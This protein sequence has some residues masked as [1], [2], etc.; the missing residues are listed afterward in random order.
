MKNASGSKST[1]IKYRILRLTLITVFVLVLVL[2]ISLYI[3]VKDAY[4]SSYENETRSL[5][6]AYSQT[7]QNTIDFLSMQIETAS[8][9][10]YVYYN[11]VPVE[12]RKNRLAELASTTM[13]KDFSVA[14]SDGTTY[15]D[16]DISDRDYFKNAM[17]GQLSISSP[18]LRKTDNSVTMMMAVPASFEEID[19][20]FYGA[21][22]C[23]QLSKGLDNIDMGE[24]SNIVVLDSNSQVIASSDTSKVIDMLV[25]SQSQNEGLKELSKHMVSGET[26]D[27]MYTSD[28]VEYLV[29]YQPL[30]DTG[31]SIAVTAN[32]SQ[33]TE[34][35]ISNLIIVNI[36]VIALVIASLIITTKVANKISIPINESVDRLSK[37]S[38][39]DIN[40]DFQHHAKNDE[41]YILAE[42]LSNTI[43]NLKMY[44]GD[45]QNVLAGIADGDLT[46]KSSVDYQ[47]D[48]IAIGNSLD[49]ITATMNGV[50]NN[51][52]YGVGNIQQGASQV[53]EGAQSL[54]N[55]AI[56]E[57]EAVDEISST[58]S[59]I[60]QKADN[61]ATISDYVSEL[62]TQANRNALDGEKLMKELAEAVENIREKS[63]AI[64]NISKTVEDIAFQTN[65]LSLNASIEAARAG[66][67]GKGFAVVAH[68]VG[69]LA[70][71]SAE[72]AQHTT[73]LIDESIQAVMS[74]SELAEKVSKAMVNI[75]GDIN[76][77]S[78]EMDKIV[79][80]AN[81]Q[82]LS[83][84][85]IASGMTHIESG[86][87]ST[88]ATAEQSAAS[89]EQLSSMSTSLADELSRFK[90]SANY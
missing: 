82:K 79:V 21:I 65:I 46:V 67:A 3:S 64:K 5:A 51:V 22:D 88:T 7:I 56:K 54:S 68:E 9:E 11:T 43:S 66:E 14:Y 28:G 15:N 69:D 8:K 31:W 85:N 84:E 53:A 52:K 20:V 32:Y 29:C 77:V 24:G 39:G 63:E 76:K 41:T 57:A 30:A 42:S 75:V 13:F 62:T 16:T 6:S 48:F 90:T 58:L 17:N 50:F 74:G 1:K 19:Y 86:M 61:T 10:D 87:H 80:A 73:V 70:T 81:E 45:I 47:G 34:K 26:G 55:I 59:S 40:S 27:M 89:S 78:D 33:V 60:Q 4:H 83:V 12:K 37:L 35:I 36:L 72:A 18:V 38:S 44:I 71:K 23:E 25:Y 49:K 2:E